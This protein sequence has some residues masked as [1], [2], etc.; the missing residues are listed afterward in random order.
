[1]QKLFRHQGVEAGTPLPLTPTEFRILS[2]LMR[3]AGE[4]VTHRQILVE[5][6]GPAAAEDTSGARCLI[7]EPGIGYRLIDPRELLESERPSAAHGLGPG[8]EGF[9][10][11]LSGS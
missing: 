6:W 11:D 5:V 8:A 7:N 1:M 9:E 2:V 4:L 3:N 10:G